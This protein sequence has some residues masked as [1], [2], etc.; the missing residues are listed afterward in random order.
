MIQLA[1]RQNYR[2]LARQ[3]VS[4]AIPSQWAKLRKDLNFLTGGT[5]VFVNPALTPG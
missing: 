3:P 1:V 4:A 5:Q 2:E